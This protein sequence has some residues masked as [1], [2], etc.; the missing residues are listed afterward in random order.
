MPSIS[1]DTDE[2]RNIFVLQGDISDL[3]ANRRAKIFMKDFLDATIKEDQIE[4]PFLSEERDYI[5]RKIQDF[6]R[7]F[8][9]TQKNSQ[10]T[11]AIL[12]DYFREEESFKIFSQQAYQIRNDQLSSENI[13]DFSEF[14]KILEKKLP[15]RILY[16]LQLLSA[17]HLAFSQNACNF[18]VPGTGKTS[19]VYGAFAYLKSLRKDNPKYIDKLM[20]IGPLSSFGPWESEYYECFGKRPRSKRL[21][22]GVSKKDRTAH[23]YSSDSAEITLLSYN[24][25]PNLEEDLAFFLS[26][27]RVMVVLD[28]AH[29]IKNTSGGIT[30]E[31]VLRLAKYCK[32]RI[33]LTGT[34]APNGYEDIFNLFKFIW[35]TKSIIPFHLFQ[36]REMSETEGDPRITKL[37]K[38]ISPYFIRIR[39]ADIDIK[40]LPPP[41]NHDPSYVS[42][43][44]V[45]REIYN[46]IEKNYLDYFESARKSEILSWILTRARLVRLMQASTNPAL[47]KKP[48]TDLLGDTITMFSE[49]MGNQDGIK[50][51]MIPD[52]FIDDSG[53]LNKILTYETF[54]IPAKFV[55]AKRLIDEI[56]S[57][58]EKVVVWAIFVQNLHDF[59]KYLESEGI[60]SEILYGATPIENDSDDLDAT[61]RTREKIIAD[62]HLPN[63]PFKVLIANPFA[64]SESI[65]LHKACHNAIYLERSFNAANFVQSKDRIHRYG[66]EENDKIHYYYILADNNT[67]FTIH[68]R[69]LDK[70]KRMMQIIESEPI[71]LFRRIDAEDEDDIKA[72]INNYV[73]RTAKA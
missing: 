34:P 48:I 12:E 52:I 8:G 63:S 18:S 46:Y 59:Q 56:L 68:Q 50:E 42:M 54:E 17:Y 30:A 35:P 9:F 23:F 1:I 39:K 26:K 44:D 58:G 67:D 72:L 29:K 3:T 71:P 66:L 62:F 11:S 55:K 53:L 45:Q 36:L 10:R 7:K 5:I 33:V 37:I 6:L 64:V 51:D 41:I 70:E 47:L 61:V 4:V 43:G 24:S 38:S 28:E 31:S 25:V 73:K 65:S 22:G 60:N 40:K 21:A 19:I 15:S 2:K 32:S 57:R 49:D 14:T 69:L 20:V 13:R 16:P 27:N